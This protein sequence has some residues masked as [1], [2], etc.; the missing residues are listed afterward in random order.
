[1]RPAFS[2]AYPPSWLLRGRTRVHDLPADGRDADGHQRTDQVEEAEGGVSEGRDRE[3][4]G[5][6]HA[7]AGPGEE[8][9]GDR[10]GILDGTAEQTSFVTAV[11]EGLAEDVGSQQDGQVLVRDDAI[12]GRARHDGRCD[13]S[14]TGA[15]EGVQQLGE[16]GDHAAGLHAGAEAHRAEDQEHRVEH[17]QHAAGGQEAVHLGMAR[18]QGQRI[19]DALH[20]AGKQDA[21]AGAFGDFRADVLDDAGLEDQGGDGGDQDRDGQHGQRR[22]P[23]PD[24]RER[25]GGNKEQ[26]GRDVELAGQDRRVQVDL[27]SVG[28]VMRQAQDR[29]DD[30]GDHDG[31]HRREEHVPDVREKGNLVDGRSHHRRVRQRG[32]LVAEVSAGDDGAGDHPV[33]EALGPADAQ[34]GDADGGNRSPRA[35]GHHRNHGADDAGGQEEHLGADDLDAVVDEGR[36][37]TA[38]RPGARNPADEEEDE[39]GAGD[40]GEVVSDGLLELFPGGL[41]E[42]GCEQH[43]DAGRGEQGHLAGAQDGV[44]AENADVDGEQRDED[45]DGD[46]GNDRRPGGG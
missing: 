17:A 19:V 11:A 23:L 14:G 36:D 41:E 15:G 43:A 25:H 16:A 46:E 20:R 32:N 8:R 37:H 22:H 33:G 39:R 29:E 18:L 2:L 31:R 3:D 4:G 34:E 27:R 24:E 1:M 6:G 44:A 7:A 13:Q 35:A 45:E 10:G 28:P 30:E 42:E 12:E 38:H 21:G 26:P 40:V 5:L 9:R